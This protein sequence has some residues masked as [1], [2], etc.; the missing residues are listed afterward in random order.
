MPWS[1]DESARD[2][3]R[4]EMRHRQ[5]PV[6]AIEFRPMRIFFRSLRLPISDTL[7]PTADAGLLLST[8]VRSYLL[9]FKTN[10][11]V[12]NARSMDA[13]FISVLFP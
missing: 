9:R 12:T 8:A 1:G 13:D 2:V 4:G 7:N 11:T 6:R 10:L 5:K 3:S